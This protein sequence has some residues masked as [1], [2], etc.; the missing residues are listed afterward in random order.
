VSPRRLQLFFSPLFPLHFP[1]E[2]RCVWVPKFAARDPEW[3]KTAAPV[4]VGGG[5]WVHAAVRHS[6]PPQAQCPAAHECELMICS[7]PRDKTKAKTHEDTTFE[8][9]QWHDDSGQPTTLRQHLIALR[10]KVAAADDA[11]QQA[12]AANESK[13]KVLKLKQKTATAK[14]KLTEAEEG[15][16]RNH[17]C[18]QCNR[19]HW[20]CYYCPDFKLGNSK[21]KNGRDQRSESDLQHV[22]AQISGVEYFYFPGSII[23][24][25]SGM[26]VEAANLL[27]YA[28]DHHFRDRA[29]E[30]SKHWGMEVAFAGCYV[31]KES[32]LPRDIASVLHAP[33]AACSV[34]APGTL[35]LSA[36][37]SKGQRGPQEVVNRQPLADGNP[38]RTK[39]PHGNPQLGLEYDGESLGE[40]MPGYGTLTNLLGKYGAKGD[41]VVGTNGFWWHECQGTFDKDKMTGPGGGNQS[42]VHSASAAGCLGNGAAC[43]ACRF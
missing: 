29:L 4:P 22:A 36:V 5:G 37:G 39:R 19:P 33:D 24:V 31:M 16:S 9:T 43:F 26:C 14:K 34:Q 42:F 28:I 41:Y 40:A 17:K 7:G 1:E 18:P 25:T 12:V 35:T 32:E 21:F 6:L 10:Q 23:V 15:M 38:L 3:M 2:A 13:D 27:K 20:C 30:L 11:V 8:I